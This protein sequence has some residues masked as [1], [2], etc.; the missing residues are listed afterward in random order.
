MRSNTCRV[1]D[2]GGIHAAKSGI[3]VRR[4][5]WDMSEIRRYGTSRSEDRRKSA[6]AFSSFLRYSYLTLNI[7]YYSCLF[8]RF[9][10]CEHIILDPNRANK[11]S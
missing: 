6:I 7:K 2:D 9:I 1:S 11:V 4:R 3:G 8:L 5:R 10:S